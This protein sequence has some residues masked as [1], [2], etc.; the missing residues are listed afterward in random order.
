[1]SLIIHNNYGQVNHIENSNVTIA[2]NGQ[3]THSVRSHDAQAEDVI[4]ITEST[5]QPLTGID[6]GIMAVYRTNICTA[7]ADWAVIVK[8]LEEQGTWHKSAFSADADYINRVCGTTVT[9][10]N[11]IARSPIFT[12]ISGKYPDWTIRPSEQ[13][14]ETASKLQTYLQI[15]ELF[16]S[17]SL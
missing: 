12:K 7:Q 17:S 16:T 15:A 9:S 1:M 5:Q 6:A 3:I 13:T 14:R 11:S 10:A 8:I 4:P 2:P